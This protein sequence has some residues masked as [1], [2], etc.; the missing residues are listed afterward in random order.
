MR[1]AHPA[2]AKLM[3]TLVPVQATTSS[4]LYPA[5]DAFSRAGVKMVLVLQDGMFLAER[6]RIAILA[7][8][9]KLP[10]AFAFCENVEDGGLLSYGINVIANYRRAAFHVDR[11][12]RG[13]K[14]GDLP[15]EFPTR[16][17]LVIN[18]ATAKAL[19]LEIPPTL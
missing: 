8:V 7:A 11:I 3:L 16:L 12:L 13:T 5:F 10:T 4:D 9:A 17:E 19:G 6:K 2:A 1:E 14:P 18:L 15:F